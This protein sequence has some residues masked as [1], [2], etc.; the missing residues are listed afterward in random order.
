[1][2]W[3]KGNV[4][5]EGP[6][7]VFLSAPSNFR[8]PDSRNLSKFIYVLVLVILLELVFVKIGDLIA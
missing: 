8:T 1:M 6:G 3:A 7:F 5:L 2:S 4:V